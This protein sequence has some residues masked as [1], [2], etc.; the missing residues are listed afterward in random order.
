MSFEKYL[1]RN[2]DKITKPMTY[3]IAN[4]CKDL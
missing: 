4:I 1:S 3:F 2:H